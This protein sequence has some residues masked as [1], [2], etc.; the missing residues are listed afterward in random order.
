MSCCKA[1][2]NGQQT[3][4][5]QALNSGLY[6]GLAFTPSE[7]MQVPRY[8]ALAM[9]VGS[10]AHIGIIRR[11]NHPQIRQPSKATTEDTNKLSYGDIF[12]LMRRSAAAVTQRR[13]EYGLFG[14]WFIWPQLEMGRKLLKDQ[15]YPT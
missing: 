4:L 11:F 1:I 15:L 3:P 10:F 14:L 12:R 13:Q 7:Q 6:C 8:H 9:H 2:G 5:I